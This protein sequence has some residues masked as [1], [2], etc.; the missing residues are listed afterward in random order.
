M[1]INPFAPNA[2]RPAPVAQEIV[3]EYN[4]AHA[5]PD[6][7]FPDFPEFEAYV[8]AVTRGSAG[9]ARRLPEHP[10]ALWLLET[11]PAVEDEHGNVKGKFKVLPTPISGN[12]AADEKVRKEV[13]TIT[14]SLKRHVDAHGRPIRVLS[15]TI[16]HPHDAGKPLHQRR[17]VVAV[18]RAPHKD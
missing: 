7:D 2:P 13:S 6:S 14:L 4:E 11:D 10:I 16:M 8:P 1:T 9:G 15:R 12:S 5:A 3:A 17:R 18:W